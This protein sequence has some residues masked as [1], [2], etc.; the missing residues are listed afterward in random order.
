MRYFLRLAYNGTNFSGWQRQPNNPTVQQI[1]EESFSTILRSRIEI[2]GCGRTDAGVHASSYIAHFDFDG[3]F[4]PGF[5]NR[6]NRFLPKDIAVHEITEVHDDA[7]ARFNAVRRSYEYHI[8][9]EKNPFLTETA[10]AVNYGDK[11]DFEKMQEAA[12][13]LLNYEDFFTFCKTNHDAKTTLCDLMRSE[14]VQVDGGKKWIFHISANR[15]LRG[16]VRLIVGMC[17]NV[18]EGKIDLETVR[19]A[20]ENKT[21]LKRAESAPA[22]GLFLTKIEY[23]FLS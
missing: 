7:H 4:P 1:L 11:L 17:L 12:K 19:E 9:F 22:H 21:Q 18:A 13:L 15:F 14:W 23:P 16:M 10:L 5:K 3:E 2:T 6:I 20:M 8:V